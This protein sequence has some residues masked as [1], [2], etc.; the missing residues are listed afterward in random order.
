MA[1]RCVITEE[2]DAKLKILEDV[3][4][5]LLG[6]VQ[7][8]RRATEMMPKGGDKLEE[9]ILSSFLHH[10]GCS[11]CS[12]FVAS[13][14]TTREEMAK[15]QKKLKTEREKFKEYVKAEKADLESLRL[16]L[17][18]QK[19]EIEQSKARALQLMQSGRDRLKRERKRNAKSLEALKE[20]HIKLETQRK[21]TDQ[22]TRDRLHKK[23]KELEEMESEKERA[24]LVIWSGKVT[25]MA[26][27][28]RGDRRLKQTKKLHDQQH[29]DFDVESELIPARRTTKFTEGKRISELSPTGFFDE[30]GR[31]T[32]A[33]N[34]TVED[35]SPQIE[36]RVRETLAYLNE[37][38]NER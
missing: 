20:W 14:E 4:Q 3:T 9:Q 30:V 21:N 10:L 18:E 25:E 13:K 34:V 32:R 23:Q 24:D 33:M 22:K 11:E 28:Y 26:K 17:E 29:E 7:R 19:E 6:I 12:P 37:I 15:Q 35:K 31:G 2:V 16:K 36:Q 8:K 5:R 1:S 38:V 27:A